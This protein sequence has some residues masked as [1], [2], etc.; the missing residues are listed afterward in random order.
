M[1]DSLAPQSLLGITSFMKVLCVF[2]INN[3]SDFYKKPLENFWEINT[4]ISIISAVLKQHG[5]E[6]KL[7]VLT[8]KT[9]LSFFDKIIEDFRP[10]IMAYSAVA[11]EF[12]FI[13]N[14]AIYAG[15]KYPEI[16]RI[17]GGVH[18]SIFPE[19]SILENFEALCVGEGEYPSLELV[20]SLEKRTN[21][22]GIRNLWIK[23][24]GNKI[25]KKHM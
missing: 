12:D 3:Y 21:P 2:S 6:T 7:A 23:T 18:V 17:I 9:P 5:H 19:E 4:G 24:Q 1:H 11:S 8:R 10:D 16:F 20:Q 14:I 22:S 13:N 15:N 25:E